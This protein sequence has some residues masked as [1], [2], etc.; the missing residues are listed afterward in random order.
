MSTSPTDRTAKQILVVEDDEDSRRA[1]T[2]ALEDEVAALDNCEAALDHLQSSPPPDLIVLEL[3]MPRMEGWDFRHRQK[4][5]PALADIL[6]VS[7]SAIGKLVDVEIALRKPLDYDEL[8][9]AVEHYVPRPVG[10]R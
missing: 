6:V 3:M 10:Q 9:T 2:N 1:L 7:V 4:Q 5:N 8:L